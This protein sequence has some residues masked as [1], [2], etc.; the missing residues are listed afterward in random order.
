MTDGNWFYCVTPF[1]HFSTDGSGHFSHICFF[2]EKGSATPTPTFIFEIVG[3]TEKK[4]Y[5]RSDFLVEINELRSLF[6]L[7]PETTLSGVI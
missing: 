4:E 6:G 1:I 7:P 2:K 3:P 5:P